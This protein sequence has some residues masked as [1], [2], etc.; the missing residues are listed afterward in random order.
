MGL[1]GGTSAGSLNANKGFLTKE[2]VPF[3]SVRR[4]NQY[5][6]D[7]TQRFEGYPSNTFVKNLSELKGFTVIKEIHLNRIRATEEELAELENL[8][9]SGV[10]FGQEETFR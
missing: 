2:L 1:V 8:L 4:R 9:K 5:V 6:A 10:V 7:D 3:I